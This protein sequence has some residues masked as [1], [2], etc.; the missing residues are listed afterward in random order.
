MRSG[1]GGVKA[2]AWRAA[3]WLQDGRRSVIAASVPR[4]SAERL[5]LPFL[6]LN[7]ARAVLVYAW[8]LAP[9][10]R[11][12][13]YM[14]A[15]TDEYG[16]VLDARSFAANGTLHAARVKEER[17]SRVFA[18]GTHGPPTSSCRALS[19]ASSAIRSSSR[20]GRTW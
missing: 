20:C 18:A 9:I 16:Y 12:G 19:R 3:A 6:L 7:C 11:D 13:G 5:L 10:L 15:W 4:P 17:V 14:P 2:L 8:L 1:A